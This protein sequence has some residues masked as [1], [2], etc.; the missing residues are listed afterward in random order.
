MQTRIKF[1]RKIMSFQNELPTCLLHI[2]E[3]SK[4]SYPSVLLSKMIFLRN[5]IHCRE[6]MGKIHFDGAILDKIQLKKLDLK[7]FS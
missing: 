2:T 5:V 4:K 1:G 7:P 3:R 6:F